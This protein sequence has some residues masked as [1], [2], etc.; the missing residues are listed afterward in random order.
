MISSFKNILSCILPAKI[1]SFIII[2]FVMRQIKMKKIKHQLQRLIACLRNTKIFNRF[3][4]ISV[5]PLNDQIKVNCYLIKY[6]YKTQQ[7]SEKRKS[8][9]KS[10]SFKF[11]KNRRILAQI[12][13]I[14]GFISSCVHLTRLSISINYCAFLAFFFFFTIKQRSIS[15][16]IPNKEP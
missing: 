6:S 8:I 10:S 1:P 12:Q 13:R 14:G 11:F 4:K 7:I 16:T 15:I 3:I 2:F 9:R 5:R